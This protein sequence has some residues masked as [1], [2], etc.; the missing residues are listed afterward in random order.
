MLV[1][2]GPSALQRMTNP[3]HSG[4]PDSLEFHVVRYVQAAVGP[5]KPSTS[6]TIPLT[7]RACRSVLRRV[8]RW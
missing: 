4:E 6:G 2:H 7:T 1:R 3:L 8:R 5:A